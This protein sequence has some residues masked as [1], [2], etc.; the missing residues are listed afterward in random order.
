MPV[1]PEALTAAANILGRMMDHRPDIA[2]RLSDSGGSLA[3]IP[4]N[5]Y[6]TEL[7]EF[8]HLSGELDPNGNPYDSF[9]IRGAGGIPTQTTTATAEENLLDLPENSTRFWDE[10]IT[11]HEW[12]HAIENIGFDDQTRSRVVGTV[13]RRPRGQPLSRN[14]RPRNRRR[15]GV[16][17]GNDPGILRRR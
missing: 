9:A 5:S 11:V 2:E 8:R 12:A 4:T 14:L 6:I 13:P 7:P 16:L 15:Q 17:R 3:I 1:S 10:D